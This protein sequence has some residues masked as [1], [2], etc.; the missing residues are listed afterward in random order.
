MPVCSTLTPAARVLVLF[1]SATHS[2]FL[3]SVLLTFPDSCLVLVR[4]TMQSSSTEHSCS[5]LMV[6]PLCPR[7]PS[8]CARAMVVATSLWVASSCVPTST[9]HG[10]HQRLPL[11]VHLVP[12]Q[13]FVPRK[14]RQRKR[15]ERTYRHSSPRRKRNTT[16]CSLLPTRQRSMD[17]S[18]ML[19][20][21]ATPASASAAVW[22]SLLQSVSRCQPRS[23]VIFQCNYYERRQKRLC[24]HCAC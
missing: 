18:T 17:T 23:M 15:P 21:L 9:M 6:R 2:I 16:T 4:S 24:S 19:S 3:S 10:H 8:H 5:T 11:W 14:P 7:L 1:A 20:N 22:L 13:C 12:W